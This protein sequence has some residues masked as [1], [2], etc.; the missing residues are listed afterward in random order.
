MQ[1]RPGLPQPQPAPEQPPPQQ[2]QPMRSVF[3]FGAIHVRKD[4]QRITAIDMDATAQRL[5]LGLASGQV[6]GLGQLQ[7]LSVL[8]QVEV[9][10]S[11]TKTAAEHVAG[12]AWHP[13]GGLAHKCLH[14]IC[15][16]VAFSAV[17]GTSPAA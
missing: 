6:W 17:L 7:R 12:A 2:Q 1:T 3:T 14:E 4:A 13:L 16:R 10:A 9:A 5:F 15:V 8:Q 11:A